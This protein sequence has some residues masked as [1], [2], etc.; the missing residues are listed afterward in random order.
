MVRVLARKMDV[1]IDS[2]G[3]GVEC[4]RQSGGFGAAKTWRDRASRVWK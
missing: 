3:D 2:R 1:V 4:S